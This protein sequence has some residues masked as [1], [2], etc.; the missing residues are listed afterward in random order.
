MTRGWISTVDDR[1]LESL[2]DGYGSEEEVAAWQTRGEASLEETIEESE[3]WF[4][5]YGDG[6][7]AD[8]AM[9]RGARSREEAE[10]RVPLPW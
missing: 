6:A 2:L 9:E 7:R 1:T 4:G 5:G 3:S 8:A 10:L